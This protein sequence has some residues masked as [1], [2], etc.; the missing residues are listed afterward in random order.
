MRLYLMQANKQFSGASNSASYAIDVLMFSGTRS[1][2]FRQHIQERAEST[3]VAYL[4]RTLAD[5]IEAEAK[6]SES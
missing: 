4:L 3:E 5:R 6:E 2:S 1:I